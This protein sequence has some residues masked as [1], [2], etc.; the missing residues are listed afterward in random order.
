MCLSVDFIGS[1]PS[2]GYYS[3]VPLLMLKCSHYLLVPQNWAIVHVKIIGIEYFV[4]K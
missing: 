2:Q 3:V 1:T 4:C